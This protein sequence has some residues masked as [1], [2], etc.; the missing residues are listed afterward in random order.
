MSYEKL[1]RKVETNTGLKMLTPVDFSRLEERIYT[2]LKERVSASTLMRLWGYRKGVEPRPYTLDV[3]AR[4]LGYADYPLFCAW[5][6]END[7]EPQSDEVVSRRI[8]TSEL[9]AGDRLL[10]TWNPGRRC[11][12]ELRKDGCFE[13]L[14]AEV[15]KLSVGDT[16]ECRLF[17]ENQPLYLSQLY[18]DSRGPMVYVAGKKDGIH[19]EKMKIVR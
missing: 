1:C 18:H 6:E 13:V 12:V 2:R 8:D 7:G 16:F 14:E 17:I 9:A 4:F 10:I 5:A 3:L 19:V 11:V 15:T